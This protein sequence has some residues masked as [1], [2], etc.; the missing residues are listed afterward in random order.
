MLK[1]SKMS[2]LTTTG[3]G[4][5]LVL[6]YIQHF[7]EVSGTKSAGIKK[8]SRIP[9]VMITQF[10]VEIPE[11]MSCPDFQRKPISLTIQQGKLGV[12]KAVVTGDP[13]PT[14]TWNRANGEITEGD[15]FNCKYDDTSGENTLEIKKVSPAE[16]DT[17]KCFAVNEYG[18]AICTATLNVIEVGFSKEKAM[19][20]MDICSTNPAELR[21]ML[22]KSKEVKPQPKDEGGIDERF[23][24]IIVSADRKDYERICLEFG[25]KDLRLI[26]KK[27]EQKKQER[28]EEQCKYVDYVKNLRHVQVRG[29]GSASFEFEM[30]LKDATSRIFLYKDGVMIPFFD[31][32]GT[33]H[34]LK[35]VGKKL[36]FSINDL[37]PEDAGLYQVDVEDVNLFSTDFKIPNVNFVVKIQEVIAQEREDAL[38]ECVLSHPLPRIRWMGKNSPLE[39][40]EKHS[41][42]VSE[43]K[44]I[45]SLLIR[46]C[47]QLDKGI[48]AAIAGIKSCS[49]WLVVQA[50]AEASGGKKASRKT[51]SAGGAGVDLQKVA[52]EQR[53]WLLGERE[54]TEASLKAK[55]EAELLEPNR[56]SVTDGAGAAV[57]NGYCKDGKERGAEGQASV[58]DEN[59][60]SR[61][62][63]EAYGL[64]A[65][66]SNMSDRSDCTNTSRGSS[67]AGGSE[68]DLKLT[69]D[70]QSG[71]GSKAGQNGSLKSKDINHQPLD[72]DA[73]S[74]AQ[75]SKDLLGN[76][77]SDGSQHTGESAA[78]HGPN[79]KEDSRS[80]KNNS[81]KNHIKGTDPTNDQMMQ[82]SNKDGHSEGKTSSSGTDGH[83]DTR[84][85]K[86]TTVEQS[87]GDGCSPD[88]NHLSGSE[89]KEVSG[90]S[91]ES[92]G[93]ARP[94]PEAL[95]DN[96]DQSIESE[97]DETE[98][99]AAKA[100][101]KRPGSLITDLFIDPG[102]QFVSGLSDVNAILGGT[103][104]IM[105]KVSS[106]D[107]EGAWFKDNQKLS[108]N[109]DFQITKDGSTHKLIIN[110][111]KE[112][113]SG[114]YRF[115][116]D[117]RK[118]EAVIYVK[119]PPRFTEED[120]SVFSKPVVIKV[121]Q[122]AVFQLPFHGLEPM[123]MQW[124]REGEELLEDHGVR[125]ERGHAHSRLLLSRC[126]RKSA[127]E[128]KFRLRNDHGTTEVVTQLVVLDRPTVPQG[129]AELVD[130][131]PTAIE[132]KW[133]PPKD[134]GGCP[135]VSYAL[136]RR[137]VGRNTWKK[138][139]EVPAV[140][141]YRDNDV[142]HGRKYCYRIRAVN[143]EGV[144][145]VME[146]DDLQAGTLAF[147][148]PPSPP[149]VVAASKDCITL[150]WAPPTFTAGSRV[151]GYSL[152]KRKKGSN[153]WSS[154]GD[155]ITGKTHAVKDVVE[156][157]E[158][159]FRVAA[160]NQSGV[161]EFS[162]PSE[163][164]FARDP[165]KPPGKVTDLK[166]TDRSYTHLSLAW[167]KPEAVAGLLDEARG[168]HVEIRPAEC[169][170]W[171]RCNVTPSI[172]PS[173]SV[174][175]LRSMEMYWVRVF[176]ANEGGESPPTELQNYVLAMP[177]PVRPRFTDQKMKSFM[178]VRAGNSVRITVNFEA[179]P[180][181]QVFWLKDNVPVAKRVTVS[182]C[183]S[184]SQLLI[185]SSERSDTG[186]YSI[187]V[188]NLVGQETFSLEVRVTDD[189]KP[190]GPITLEEKVPGTVTV[191]WE[192]S[193]DEQRDDRLHYSVC[194]L[195][196][197]RR[198]WSTAA[199]RL[200][201]NQLTVCSVMPG[202]EYH[203]WV[204]A[205]NDMGTSA[206]SVSPTWGTERKK[207]RF[208]VHAPTRKDPD[209]RCAP[210]F[211]V[212][213]KCHTAPKGYEC[214]MSC[215][216]TGNPKPRV[217]WY[218][219]NV[220]LNT[221]TSYHV[222]DV[223]GVC[224]MLILRVTPK[225]VGE[226]T[227]LAENALGRAECSTTLIVIE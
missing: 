222:S 128:I 25:V 42:T 21:K 33:K 18:R 181:P 32:P 136:E 30:E 122:N 172:L 154:V 77:V 207:E 119:D 157:M 124:F 62:K 51:T 166:V 116:A 86:Q 150:S 113:H 164:V 41:I 165:K 14:V 158:Y 56:A 130:S 219:D 71:T 146:T 68:G 133:R 85:T 215:A 174:K 6:R 58:K 199:E 142:E 73:F 104:E 161:G 160:V 171:S 121:G 20:Q 144:S 226:Y 107:C 5:S 168:Y 67:S 114:K 34:S 78:L 139:G 225:D 50:D 15:K 112:E 184:S 208:V 224:S 134:E 198:T 209:P 140:A 28:E 197:S 223:C 205:K 48:Y 220:S 127:G 202:R 82:I 87:N 7:N 204:Y 201:N 118:T 203:F 175:G 115:E 90:A 46:D 211:M 23:W 16:A 186:V 37:L 123:K 110:N 84:S 129:P 92:S 218:R 54:R 163:F 57:A 131:S 24:E 141:G 36:V 93:L 4:R 61:I 132:F 179:M 17:Y 176:A 173:Y 126:S 111:C 200:F 210:S 59:A 188:K 40:G 2:D 44:L 80:A 76:D 216:V 153:L 102:V 196:S 55:G 100:K 183:D 3:Q 31:D 60:G 89:G 101:R 91:A 180:L 213:L 125:I 65:D 83:S 138:L 1:R 221:N 9:G 38:F 143:A 120:L 182:N 47:K 29:D 145:D 81:M 159:E 156:S 194:A 79:G 190:P 69:G 192:P 63:A 88:Q 13:K 43:D 189:P 177:L 22:K 187:T 135:L 155:L 12:F 169:S 147:P 53:L 206:P 64:G 39:D 151:L 11:G 27:L 72:K 35:T 96:A 19:E 227:V 212:P 109:D 94:G 105:C 167:T 137:Q 162:N 178:V 70:N 214:Y 95:S 74:K 75:E 185:P 26:L 52:E 49:A 149:K 170:E 106:E 99:S 193:P 98:D 108:A 103:A 8:K 195:D 97:N 152:E 117:G 191:S 148:G 45:H 10:V 66:G 217:T